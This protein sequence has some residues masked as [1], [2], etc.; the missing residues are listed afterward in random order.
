MSQHTTI[1]INTNWVFKQAGD[2]TT[3]TESHKFLPVAQFPTNVH[4]DLIANKIIPDPFVGKNENDVQWVGEVPWVYKTSFPS[5][6]A[7]LEGGN[8]STKAVI[9][10]DGLDTYATVALNG[11]EILKTESMFIP[12]RVDV[13]S[14]LKKGEEE[15]GEENELVIT[16]ESAYLTG[17]KIIEE[18]PDHH[19]GCWNGDTSRL[20]VRKA[21][22]HWGWDWGPTLLTC[23]PWRPISLEIFSA[24]ISDLYFTSDVHKSLASAKLVARADVEGVEEAATEIRFDISLDGREVVASQTVTAKEG[25][26]SHTF[27]I[28]GPALSLWYPI[29]Y[30][31]Q[32]LYTLTATLLDGKKK[33]QLD[34]RSKRFGLRRAELVQGPLTDQPGTSFYF[35]INNIPIFCGG[36]N[37]IPADSFLPRITPQKYYDWVKLV[38][39]GNQFM[40]RVWGGGIFEEQAF[41]DACDELGILVWQD[42]MFACGN[43]PA[44]PS[45]L[46]LVQRE[47]EANIKLLRHHPSIVIWAGNNEDYQYQESM[48]L[49]YD[50]ADQDPASWLATDFPARYIYEKTL[51][52]ACATLVPDTYY[53]FGS[54]W[55]GGKATTDP[56]VGDLHQW[57]VWHG[58]QERYQDFDRLAGRFVSEFGMEAF[59]HP[60]TISAFLP[61]GAADPDRYA[62]SAT[63]DFHNKAAGQA[64]RLALYLAENVRYA[65]DGPLEHFVY[66]TQ[67]LQAECL[68]AAYRLWKRQWKG[69]GGREYCG[70]AL[71]W[72]AND[73]WPGTSWSVADFFLRPKLAYFAVKR[74]MAPVTLGVKRSVSHPLAPRDDEKKTT[75]TETRTT[76]TQLEIWATNLTLATITADLVLKAFNVV[77]GVETFSRTIASALSLPANRSTEIDALD[78]PV[79][80]PGDEDRTVVAA[81]LFSTGPGPGA[82]EKLAR[83]VNWP[84]PLRYVHLQRPQRLRCV[85]SADGDAE[86]VELSAEVPVKGVAVECGD[87]D[88][89]E[90]VVFGDNLVDLVPGEVVCIPVAGAGHGTVLTT[91]Y[92]GMAMSMSS[93]S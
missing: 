66:T 32:P 45:F 46:S 47:A 1:P 89:E 28:D 41:Y 40:I 37:W 18:H 6:S 9:A 79:P 67:L 82:G 77:T 60:K 21:Q 11:T 88:E 22:Y 80:V 39:D 93:C 25:L 19:W 81:Y 86:V 34:T 55:G 48:K 91:R 17:C 36:S 23:G 78:V 69:P 3:S 85:L 49:T 71:V 87:E 24:R 65:P 44:F 76:S 58:T 64:R 83:C 70:G 56:T 57:N 13:T 14:L 59:P 8:N 30:G 10:F 35:R 75:T 12:E 53:H 29:R 54:P 73:C 33:S 84:E 27:T 5:P 62:Q 42:F 2:N 92:M 43:Y 63:L 74:E 51:A 26:A 16:F 50:F 90:R 20:A 7:F 31:A 68:A 52:D 38:A 72:Q 15:G 61:G 4:L